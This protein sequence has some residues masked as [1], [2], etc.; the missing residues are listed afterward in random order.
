MAVHGPGPLLNPF[1]WTQSGRRY[2]FAQQPCLLPDCGGSVRGTSAP[3]EA[4]GEQVTKARGGPGHSGQATRAGL[5]HVPRLPGSVSMAT[6]YLQEDL[7]NILVLPVSSLELQ[8]RAR[9]TT[10]SPRFLSKISDMT[11]PLEMSDFISP[12][13]PPARVSDGLTPSRPPLGP[14][15]PAASPATRR[16]ASRVLSVALTA[17]WASLPRGRRGQAAPLTSP[18]PVNLS[19]LR[20]HLRAAV[21]RACLPSVSLP[22]SVDLTASP[23]EPPVLPHI[24]RWWHGRAQVTVPVPALESCTPLIVHHAVSTAAS[25]TGSPDSSP[26]GRPALEG[27]LLLVAAAARRLPPPRAAVS[28]GGHAG[29][30]LPADGLPRALAAQSPR[31]V[32]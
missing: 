24:S 20:H 10:R 21:P 19:G 28:L 25:R 9:P 16:S 5:G 8:S 11:L 7:V 27:P 29:S 1:R 4:M 3:D 18:V 17:P 14:L 2:P 13:Y 31:S 12:T 6:G 22:T 15:C 32:P 30:L 23:P 26:H